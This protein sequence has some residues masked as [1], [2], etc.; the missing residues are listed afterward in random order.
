[1]IIALI[2]STTASAD[3]DGQYMT[4][5]QEYDLDTSEELEENMF[6]ADLEGEASHSFSDAAADV[7][8][9]LQECL[10]IHE[11][12]SVVSSVIINDEYEN[13][14][15]LVVNEDLYTSWTDYLYGDNEE[16]EIYVDDETTQLVLDCLPL[17]GIYGVTGMVLEKKPAHWPA[18]QECVNQTSTQEDCEDCA[19]TQHTKCKDA[20]ASQEDRLKCSDEYNNAKRWQCSKK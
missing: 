13:E 6:G 18:F 19:D 16:S 2:F 14:S 20:A 3:L 8:D 17:Y 15:L 5:F 1:M 10:V 12:D 9:A 7:T 11:L 4:D